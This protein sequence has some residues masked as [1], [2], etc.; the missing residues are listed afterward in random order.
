[1]RLQ[2]HSGMRVDRIFAFDIG[3]YSVVVECRYCCYMHMRS[4]K[5]DNG[6]SSLYDK[7]P[8]ECVFHSL[9][10]T[11]FDWL[12]FQKKKKSIKLMSSHVIPRLNLAS[13]KIFRKWI[14]FAKKKK[15]R[16][17]IVSR[18]CLLSFRKT[19]NG[20]TVHIEE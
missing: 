13:G 18:V 17:S 15:T 1:M 4:V 20:D 7:R 9:R 11:R 10:T 8:D 19:Q 6:T 12:E 2:L 3:I 16:K 5:R 14:F